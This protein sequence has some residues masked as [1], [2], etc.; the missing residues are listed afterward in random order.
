V[1][2]WASWVV[3]EGKFYSMFESQYIYDDLFSTHTSKHVKIEIPNE[4][5]HENGTKTPTTFLQNLLNH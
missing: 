3:D 2:G 4:A 5:A 1:A